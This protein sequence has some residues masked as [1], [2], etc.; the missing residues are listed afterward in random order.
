M[1]SH[2]HPRPGRRKRCLLC[3]GLFDPD[4][5]TKGKQQYC[6]KEDCQ[7]FRQRQNEYHWR[8]QNPDCVV[9]QYEQSKQWQR[10]RPQYS[11]QRRKKYPKLA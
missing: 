4:P 5:R 9:R 2:N 10:D 11:R 1:E 6:S 3:K 7:N 8:N